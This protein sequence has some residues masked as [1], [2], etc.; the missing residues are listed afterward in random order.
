MA[1]T[2]VFTFGLGSTMHA[3]QRNIRTHYPQ[4]KERSRH[5]E[6]VRYFVTV[7]SKITQGLVQGTVYYRRKCLACYRVWSSNSTHVPTAW[8]IRQWGKVWLHHMESQEGVHV[9][10]SGRPV[11][12]STINPEGSTATHHINSTR[13]RSDRITHNRILFTSKIQNYTLTLLWKN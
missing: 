3:Y 9:L 2:Y 12:C 13:T 8:S 10:L 7:N 4:M 1:E 5:T 11:Q 6:V